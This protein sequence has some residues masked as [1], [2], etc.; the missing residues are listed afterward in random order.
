MSIEY[1]LWY[2]NTVSYYN[3][4]I[5]IRLRGTH[6]L[7]RIRKTSVV[8]RWWVI[9]FV[10]DLTR[11]IG[12]S[13]VIFWF[14]SPSPTRA[15]SLE[16][17]STN[18]V[19][20]KY[21]VT[22]LLGIVI[23]SFW[24]SSSFLSE[25]VSWPCISSHFELVTFFN[26]FKFDKDKLCSFQPST[27]YLPNQDSSSYLSLSNTPELEIPFWSHQRN[28]HLSFTWGQTLTSKPFQP[29]AIQHRNLDRRNHSS[30]QHL[31]SQPA[32]SL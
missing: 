8:T 30:C 19:M 18:Q 2:M 15:S 25:S 21:K 7:I 4:T 12:W 32:R 31:V 29:A 5:C 11:L 6:A 13:F 9:L 3:R 14:L 1:R 22:P 26:Q 23:V 27:I 28:G 17:V 24:S 20:N 10:G 16:Q